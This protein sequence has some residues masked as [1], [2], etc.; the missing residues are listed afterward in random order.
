MPRSEASLFPQAVSLSQYLLAARIL[1]HVSSNTYPRT[2]ILEHVSSSTYPRAAISYFQSV[3]RS[4][5]IAQQSLKQSSPIVIL[6][7]PL[8]R[9]RRG[10]LKQALYVN[11]FRIIHKSNFANQ[12][13]LTG[14]IGFI[15]E[16]RQVI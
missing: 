12:H 1:E 7:P 11:K 14:K 5:E 2:R 9:I 4:L 6:G 16:D 10:I 3:Y 13:S 8:A 15:V